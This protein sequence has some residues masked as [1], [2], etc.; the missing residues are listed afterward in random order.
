MIEL[1]DR[2]FGVE[3]ECG[4]K[5]DSDRA[6]ELFEEVD[7]RGW[8]I[9]TDGSGV[10]ACSPILQGEE[11]LTTLQQAMSVLLEGGAYITNADGLHV[12]HD[13]PEF[14]AKPGLI[15]R[16][17]QS[18]RANEERIHEMVAPMRRDYLCCPSWTDETYG[19]LEQWA[20]GACPPG[21]GVRNERGPHIGRKDLNISAIA[22]HGTVEI[23]LH[24]GCLDFDTAA[25]W[26]AFGQKFIDKVLASDK[27]VPKVK[28]A[29]EFLTAIALNAEAAA[30]LE[31]KVG[32]VADPPTRSDIPPGKRGSPEADHGLIERSVGF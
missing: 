4:L 9:H 31:A 22:K 17:V 20:S 14:I 12:H 2:R 30:K 5:G 11:G 32:T 7:L 6:K 23:R 13:A 15:L 28:S 16:L 8:D 1:T 10:E 26:I 27:P 19:L 29:R 24:E 18:W 25:A 3:V 21:M